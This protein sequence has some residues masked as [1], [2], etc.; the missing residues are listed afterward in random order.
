MVT[1]AKLTP[2]MVPEF[3]NGPLNPASPQREKV[4]THT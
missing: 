4:R 2:H 3:L 1:G